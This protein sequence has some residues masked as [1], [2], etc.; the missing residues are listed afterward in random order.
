MGGFLFVSNISST[1][2]R[3]ALAVNCRAEASASGDKP[4]LSCGWVN[5]GD[6]MKTWFVNQKHWPSRF[7]CLAA[8]CVF[9]SVVH[10]QSSGTGAL[11]G[12]VSDQS[13][14]SVPNATVTLTNSG[15]NQERST[16]TGADGVYKFSLLSPGTYRVRFAAAGFKSAEVSGVVIDVTETPL[17]DK[18]LEVGAVTQTVT[19]ESNV[20]TLQTQSSTL[21][22]T[23]TGSNITSLPTSSRNYTEILTLSAGASASV[24]NASS[25]GKGTQDI[26]VNGNDPGENNYQMDGVAI[27]DV[28]NSGSANDSGIYTGVAIPNPD[29]IAEFKIQT[30]TYDASY[31]RNAGGNVNVVTKSG[32]NNFHGTAFEFLRNT[33]LNANEFFFKQTELADGDPNKQAPL[34]QNQFGGTIGG[35]IKKDKLFFFGSY[36]GTRSKNGVDPVVG[37]TFG[38]NLPPIPN[39]SRGTCPLGGGPISGCDTAAQTFAADLAEANCPANP[40]NAGNSA[41]LPFIPAPFVTQL[42]CNGSNLNP[43]ALRMLQVAGPAS[44]GGYYIPSNT[45]KG[46]SPEPSSSSLFGSGFTACSFV[47]P[48]IRNE[49]QGV[50]SLDYIVNSKNTLSARFFASVSPQITAGGQLPGYEGTATYNNVNALL[51]LTTVVSNNFV[52]ELHASYQRLFTKEADT[53]PAGATTSNFGMTVIEPSVTQ[54]PPLIMV[55]G[56]T[57]LFGGLEPFYSPVNQFQYGDQISWSHGKHTIRAG[58]EYEKTQWNLLFG[59]LERGLVL[60]GNWNDLFVGQP[61]NVVE[62]LF[63]VKSFPGGIPHEYRLPN[64]NAYVQD[65]WKVNSRLTLNLGVRWEFDGSLS[66]AEGNSTNIWTSLLSTVAN[67]QVPLSPTA[68]GGAPCAASFVGNVVPRN[69]IPHYGQPPAGAIVANGNETISSHPPYSNFAPRFGFAWQPLSGNKLVVRGGVGIF[70]DR[71]G[72]NSF[73]HGLEQGNPYSATV[74][75]GFPNSASLQ[76]LFPQAQ[77]VPIPGYQARYYDADCVATGSCAFPTGGLFPNSPGSSFL[78]APML[79]QT[80]H[81]PLVQEYNLGIQYEFSHNWVLDLGYVGS[82]GINLVDY[83]HNFNTAQL[84][85][86]GGSITLNGSGGPVVVTNN[87]TATS[88]PACRSWVTKP[89]AYKSRTSTAAPTTTACKSLCGINSPVA[90]RCRQRTR[91]ASPLLTCL[92]FPP[93]VTM[94]LIWVSSMVHPSTTTIIASS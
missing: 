3:V 71:V 12:T 72:L 89:V 49:D 65:D 47:I 54:P 86:T 45:A 56:N 51:K 6:A 68:C 25:F 35:P 1:G 9:A 32:T 70:Y 90:C 23:V 39:E 5:R 61:G 19:V 50:G 36:Q 59:G 55:Q 75:Y 73:V 30:S 21:G 18:V 22:T 58:G 64:L 41:F 84:I 42:A 48:A 79:D 2:R 74:D 76:S 57:T 67:D 4:I 94:P 17:L 69:S 16:T 40:A 43:I 81:T 91:G 27:N 7:A 63:C 78:S 20:E 11:T 93:T 46:C 92:V 31:G 77:T 26:S 88:Q 53:L 83:N 62:C 33:V 52:N 15:T 80:I 87:S 60:V 37:N 38:V 13:G 82:T 85:P 8:L 66:D 44:S 24:N 34:N 28:A 29:A 14:K 10:A